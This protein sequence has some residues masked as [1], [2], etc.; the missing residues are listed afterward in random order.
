MATCQDI[1]AHPAPRLDLRSPCNSEQD[2]T[3]VGSAQT[4]HQPQ[5]FMVQTKL[6]MASAV[7]VWR[8]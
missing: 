6:E 7:L 5:I 8:V 1:A 3:H 2:L 4:W